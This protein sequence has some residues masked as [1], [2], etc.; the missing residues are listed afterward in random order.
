LLVIASELKTGIGN[1]FAA[2]EL[3]KAP[4]AHLVGDGVGFLDDPRGVLEGDLV[5][6]L[7]FGV[8]SRSLVGGDELLSGGSSFVDSGIGT[9]F[10]GTGIGSTSDFVGMEGSLLACLSH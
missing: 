9:T 4:P 3:L 7:S 2:G 1:V 8:G 5:L 10:E 6:E